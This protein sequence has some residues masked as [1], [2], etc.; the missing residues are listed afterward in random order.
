MVS[1]QSESILFPTLAEDHLQKLITCG[2]IVKLKP[3]EILFQEGE[4]ADSFYVVLDGE[5]K[6][7]K[8]LGAEELVITIH[9]RGEFTGDLSMLTGGI[10]SATASSINTSSV[11]KFDD[12]KELL[13]NCPDSIDLFIPALAE[14]S[15]DLE[16][17]L[18]QQEKLAALGKLSAGLAHELNNPAAAGRR[19]AKQLNSAISN[20]QFQMLNLR[21]KHFSAEHRQLLKQLQAQA[22][23]NINKGLQLSPLEQSDREDILIDWLEEKG[24]NNSWEVAPTLVSGGIDKSCLENLTQ[25]MEGDILSEALLWLEATLN[26][27]GLVGEVEQSTSRISDLV[28]AI[29]NYSYMDR[30]LLQEVD[31]HEGIDN[32]LKILHHKLKYGVKVNQEYSANVPKISAYGSKL[33]QVWTNLIDNAI[34]AMDGKGELTGGNA[35][36]QSAY[37]TPVLTIRTSLENN[38]VL[39]EIIDNGSGIPSEI[40]PRI[41]EPFYTS[42][43]VGKG[44]GLGLDI[45]RRI[46]VQEHKGNI[47][48]KSAP[49][50]TNFQVRLPIN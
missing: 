5:I 1:T 31:L 19:A 35:D 13:K 4:N 47:R 6:I 20:L 15:K 50:C 30:A 21:G 44:T 2:L 7:T 17:R 41:F 18:R 24:V 11:I 36:G 48:F 3:G 43:E 22:L 8:Q 33:N 26:M 27:N 38:C 16:I 40:Q 29:K 42:K 37:S 39:V 10:C 14:R 12:F 28:S 25:S 23:I 45:S 9:R 34:D 49:G 46:I 32:T